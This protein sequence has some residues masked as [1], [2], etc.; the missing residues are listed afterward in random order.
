[1]GRVDL[2]LGLGFVDEGKLNCGRGASAGTG[3]FA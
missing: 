2:G 1:M 3:G